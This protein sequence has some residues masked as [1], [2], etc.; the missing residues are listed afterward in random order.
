MTEPSEPLASVPAQ[1]W[2]LRTDGACRGNPGHSAAGI[3]IQGPDGEVQATGKIYLG[4]MTNNQAE[5]RALI[6]GL[7]AIAHYQPARV[8]VY[9]DSELVV[10][11]M[12]GVYKVR[13]ARLEALWIEARAL[14]D[15]LPDVTFDAVPR[16]QNAL[17]DQLANEALDA[18]ARAG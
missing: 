18:R 11:Q 12:Q 8:H 6:L 14:V 1:E 7:K 4:V 10:N 9:M 3:V 13:D 15:A 5:Y 17:A 2:I 16:A